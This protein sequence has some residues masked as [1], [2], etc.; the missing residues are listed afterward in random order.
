MFSEILPLRAVERFFGEGGE[1]ERGSEATVLTERE[2][3]L[4]CGWEFERPR[5]GELGDSVGPTMIL[6]F[7]S[8]RRDLG[9]AERSSGLGGLEWPSFQDMRSAPMV[10]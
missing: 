6:V 3:C 4:S 7:S 2:R 1:G 10:P 9:D 8:A 5:E